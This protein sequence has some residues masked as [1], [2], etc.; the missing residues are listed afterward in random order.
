MLW[1]LLQSVCEVGPG[2]GA[3]E[4]KTPVTEKNDKHKVVTHDE[5]I[6]SQ[7]LSQNLVQSQIR[8]INQDETWASAQAV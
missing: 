2:T 3:V 7:I 8:K 5:P 4:F 6:K 1:I